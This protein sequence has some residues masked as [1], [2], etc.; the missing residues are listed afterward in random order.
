MLTLLA[1]DR[2]IKGGENTT[3]RKKGLVPAVLY[4]PKIQAKNL[5]VD[6]GSFRKAYNETGGASMLELDFKDGEVKHFV[7]IKDFQMHPLSRKI[8]HVDFYQPILSEKTKADIPIILKGEALVVS[9]KGGTLIKNMSEIQVSAL[10]QKLPSEIVIDV[11]GLSDFNSSIT[12]K[13][14]ELPE[15]VEVLRDAEDVIVSVSAPKTTKQ[16][17]QELGMAKEDLFV[18]EETVIEEPSPGEDAGGDDKGV[19]NE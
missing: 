4:G 18:G 14:L 11:S 10:P 3:L 6:E 2:I 5:F 12:V 16:L 15:G 19:G 13:D 17:E 1:Q 7:L 8:M 9:E